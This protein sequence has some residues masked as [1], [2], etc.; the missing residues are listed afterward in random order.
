M[1]KRMLSWRALRVTRAALLGVALCGV[2]LSPA[3]A[4]AVRKDIGELTPA[5][6]ASLRRGVAQMMAWDSAPRGSA[7]YRRSWRYWANMH[8]H[9]SASDCHYGPV[10]SQAQG[11]QRMTNQTA[12]GADERQA[13]CRCE[14][15]TYG[16]LTWHRMYLYYFEQVLRAAAQDPN[17]TLPYWN[18]ERAPALPAAFRPA[19]YVVNGATRP[20]PLYAA[21]RRQGL[22]AGTRRL[23]PSVVSTADA[24]RQPVYFDGTTGFNDLL[25]GSPHGNVHC[26]IGVAGCGSGLMGHPASAAV[27][28]IFYLH[29]VN[30]DRLYDC[31]ARPAPGMRMPKDPARLSDRYTFP[32]GAGVMRTRQVRDMLSADQ[33]G[34]RYSLPANCPAGPPAPPP[35]GAPQGFTQ[36]Q[37]YSVGGAGDIGPIDSSQPLALPQ[38]ARDAVQASAL[39][40][41]DAR[42]HIIVLKGVRFD[43][44]PALLY[45]VYLVGENGQ[46]ALLGTMNFFSA[47]HRDEDG[48][49]FSFDAT[50]AFRTLGQA[51]A[52]PR[53]EFVATTGYAQ[54]SAAEIQDLAKP[55]A[56][57]RYD[58]VTLIT[59]ER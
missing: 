7:N 54:E 40:A 53:L 26:A 6:L 56:K 39:L 3:A 37:T 28:P 55:A 29:H 16:F 18:Y 47:G 50:Q 14:H 43:E 41:A 42:Q 44:Q 5:E 32:D 8:A 38:A 35:G 2:S 23:D 57:L 33:L 10:S 36:A 11:M 17:L 46:R 30:I 21:E 25:E 58:S 15:G 49:T 45:K 27:D 34:Y 1:F 4:Q 20:N 52:A 13:W 31:W 19:T 24:F 48:E 22:N 51:P 12:T 9:F 59:R